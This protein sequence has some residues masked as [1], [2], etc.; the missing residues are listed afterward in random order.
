[1]AQNST[2]GNT[3]S[4]FSFDWGNENSWSVLPETA[5][6][7]VL[8]IPPLLKNPETEAE[9]LHLWGKWMQLKSSGNKTYDLHFDYR[10]LSEMQRNLE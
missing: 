5:A 3:T 1:M 8:T 4:R 2:Y 7:L 10:R 6:T 9:R